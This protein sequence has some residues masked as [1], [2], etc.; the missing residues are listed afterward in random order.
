MCTKFQTKNE[1]K[2]K[3]RAMVKGPVRSWKEGWEL[4]TYAAFN[5]LYEIVKRISE[6]AFEHYWT[7]T[8]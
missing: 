4:L 8:E 7:E 6:N 3:E 1:D 2:S 5:T